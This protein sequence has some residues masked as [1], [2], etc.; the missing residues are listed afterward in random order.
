M[1]SVRNSA[2]LAPEGPADY[3]AKTS[4]HWVLLALAGHLA[5][6]PAGGSPVGGSPVW[7]VVW[8]SDSGSPAGS[9][10]GNLAGS[11]AGSPA[12]IPADFVGK[13]ELLA[14]YP[15]GLVGD[16]AESLAESPA[17]CYLPG[18]LADSAENPG[19]PAVLEA[20]AGSAA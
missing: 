5:G 6:C 3:S 16:P 17:D 4:A 18:T 2:H 1:G 10:D 14:H 13:L 11:P 9:P 12:G 8:S 7:G 19:E 15:A 20:P